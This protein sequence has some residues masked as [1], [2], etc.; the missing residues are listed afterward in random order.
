MSN[1]TISPTCPTC[2]PPFRHQRSSTDETT[3]AHFKQ[4]MSGKVADNWENVP[5]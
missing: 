5:S 3:V 2:C 1:N 4:A